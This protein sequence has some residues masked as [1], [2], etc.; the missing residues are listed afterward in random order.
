M[1]AGLRVSGAW[2]QLLAEWLDREHLQAPAIR[3]ELERRK[4]DE[5]IPAKIWSDLLERSVALKPEAIA[6]GLAIGL[7]V[8]P[9]H[10]S[11]L[12]YLTLASS[13]LGEA[14]LAY[15]RYE[16]LFLGNNAAEV[17]VVGADMEMHWSPEATISQLADCVALSVLITFCR[18]LLANSALS[19]SLVTFVHPVPE[20]A[21]EVAA[22]E[23]FFGCPVHFDDSHMRVRFPTSF[24]N[25]KLVHGD[26]GLY[27][28]YERQAEALLLAQPD[29]DDF[30]RELQR[31][32]LKLLPDGSAN[33]VQVA[34]ELNQSV[35][36]LQ[37]RLDDRGV[38]W[39]ALLDR[40][41]E[42]LAIKY[43]GDHSLSIGDITLLLGFSEQSA[44]NHAFQ[45]WTGTTPA[46]YRR[47]K[48]TCDSG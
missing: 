21:D 4:Y 25:M 48:K 38:T 1:L 20:Q 35:R 14:M 33:V 37:R 27:V 18:N 6:P 16:R 3:D 23:R 8:Q 5:E 40:T 7:L 30:D 22:Y 11:I 43:L 10:I 36:T 47:E 17:T 24:L 46:R 44:F 39:K 29:P 26:P 34:H 31:V 32:I 28:L 41:R 45:R 19:P 9:K 2:I 13:T 42:Q 15:L 12:G